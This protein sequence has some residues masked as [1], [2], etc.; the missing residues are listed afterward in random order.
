MAARRVLSFGGAH[1]PHIACIAGKVTPW[2]HEERGGRGTKGKERD[3]KMAVQ[4]H[5]I[6]YHV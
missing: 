1:L 2:Q 4:K 3:R 6:S 5:E